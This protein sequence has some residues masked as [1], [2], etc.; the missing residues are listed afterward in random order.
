M[1]NLQKYS[2][3]GESDEKPLD[4]RELEKQQDHS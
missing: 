3:F 2:W 1:I 4:Y